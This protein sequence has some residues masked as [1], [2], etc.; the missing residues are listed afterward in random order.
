[1]GLK[2]NDKIAMTKRF[3]WKEQSG[4]RSECNTS[5]LQ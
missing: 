1:M 5:L 2:E 3:E 4:N